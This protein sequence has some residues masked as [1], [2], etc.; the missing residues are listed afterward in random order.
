M[1]YGILL[2]REAE[3]DLAYL[4]VP[5]RRR[6]LRHLDALGEYTSALSERSHFPWREK[7]QMSQFDHDYDGYRWEFY[8]L[9]QY[10]QDETKLHILRICKSSMPLSDARD[11]DIPPPD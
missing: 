10:S 11:W 2:S 3:H 7:C 1:S 8:I 5:L 4:L 9:F 6:V